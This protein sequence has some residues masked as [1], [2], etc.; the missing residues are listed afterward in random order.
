MAEDAVDHWDVLSD[1]RNYLEARIE[2]KKKVGWET[3]YDEREH[4]ALA[5]ALDLLVDTPAPGVPLD[6]EHA[7]YLA[8][9]LTLGEFIEDAREAKARAALQGDDLA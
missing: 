4:A 7:A 6:E 2:A 9:G 1:R 3:R 8:S 5:W